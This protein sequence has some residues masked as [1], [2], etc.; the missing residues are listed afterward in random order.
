MKPEVP[1]LTAEFLKTPPARHAERVIR[2]FHRWLTERGVVLAELE[3]KHVDGFL[4]CPAGETISALTRNDYRY[5]IRR[6]V[7]WLHWKGV[8]DFDAAWLRVRHQMLPAH[9]EQF[10]ASLEPTLRPAT[11]GQYRGSLRELHNWLA[12]EERPLETLRREEVSLWMQHLAN[13][14]QSPATRLNIIVA[15]RVYLRALNDAGILREPADDLSRQSDLPKLPRYLPRPLEPAT[16]EILRE[17]LAAADDQYQL[18][19]LVMRNTGMRIGE[20]ASV[21]FNCLRNDPSGNRFLKVPLGK[22]NSE[23]LVPI[24]QTTYELVRRL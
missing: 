16:D 2:M 9:A 20:L 13:K 10:L 23:R 6:Y 8:I 21:E 12:K 1:D 15:V 7:D 5:K 11:C 19:L 4:A 14:G 3:R 18:G 22:L 17:R 24:D